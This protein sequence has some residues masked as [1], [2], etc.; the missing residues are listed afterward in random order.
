MATACNSSVESKK[1]HLD[2]DP[3]LNNLG[4]VMAV[5]YFAYLKDFVFEG[6]TD[7]LSDFE[8]RLRT[9]LTAPEII[10]LVPNLCSANIKSYKTVKHVDNLP[11]VLQYVAGTKNRPYNLSVYELV[12]E[13]KYFTLDMAQCLDTILNIPKLKDN[14]AQKEKIREQFVSFLIS[15]L[16]HE[17]SARG[18]YKIAHFNSDDDLRRCIMESL[19]TK[20][21]ANVEYPRPRISTIENIGKGMAYWFFYN[22]LNIMLPELPNAMKDWE[23]KQ[24]VPLV[25]IVCI[26]VPFSCFCPKNIKTP[27]DRNIQYA[28]DLNNNEHKITIGATFGRKYVKNVLKIEHGEEKLYCIAEY[29]TPIRQLYRMYYNEFENYMP[30]DDI[31]EEGRKE[32]SLAKQRHEFTA[33]LK[34]ILGKQEIYKVIPFKDTDENKEPKIL[35]ELLWSKLRKYAVNERQ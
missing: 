25:K 27:K 19:A 35:S 11:E 9:F 4:I 30:K 23:N 8:D 26:L 16:E 13:G 17:D 28:C 18:Q 12:D 10:I 15:C 3:P 29:A 31:C 7:R 20:A 32:E 24:K 21:A 1:P 5:G 34:K 6:L 22:Y 2:P 14:L 33:C